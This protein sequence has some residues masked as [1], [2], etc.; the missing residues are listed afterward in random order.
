MKY[1][2]F[3]RL[4]RRNGWIRIRTRGSHYTYSKDGVNVTVP[5][6]GSQEMYEPLR[7]RISKQMALN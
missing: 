4:I 7:K 6:H 1:S 5:F 3:H 2:E